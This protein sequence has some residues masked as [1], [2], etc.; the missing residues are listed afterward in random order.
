MSVTELDSTL[1]AIAGDP[2]QPGDDRTTSIIDR[3]DQATSLLAGLDVSSCDQ[4]ELGALATA[5]RRT[6]SQVLRVEL[7]LADRSKAF[8]DAGQ[9]QDP[10]TLLGGAG[11]RSSRG[12]KQLLRHAEILRRFPHVAA[13]LAAGEFSE[14]HL[15]A[16]ILA[17]RRIDPALRDAFDALDARL[18]KAAVRRS[19][20]EFRQELTMIVRNIEAD[21]RVGR[22]LQQ[23]RSIRLGRWIDAVTGMYCLRGQFDPETGNRI[24]ASVDTEIDALRAAGTTR[25]V[26]GDDPNDPLAAEP[27]FLAAHALARLISS[28]HGAIRPGVPEVV[29][30]TDYQTMSR[31]PHPD[32]VAEYHDGTPVEP[33]TIARLCCDAI[34]RAVTLSADGTEVLAMGRTRRTATLAQR[35]ALRAIYRGCA[36][37]GCD[38]RFDWCQIHH[39][40]V[41]IPEGLT[42]LDN[43]APLCNRHHHQVHEG[44]WHL[45]LAPDR[46]LTLSR[47]D[48]TPYQTMR[49]PGL[50]P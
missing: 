49:P 32:T 28:G 18:A 29:V 26:P 13:V 1:H 40:N 8:F 21:H 19:V 9:G 12:A 25:L 48:G 47:P 15:D 6:R 5:L 50:T 45:H 44:R 14:A 39:V 27:E 34:I 22:D 10:I 37:D 36:I 33:T 2:R 43:L 4:R 31:G 30:L 42:D 3:V 35:R 23:R 17:R 46:T 38:T 24:F 16:L 41:W 11:G 20:D 7:A